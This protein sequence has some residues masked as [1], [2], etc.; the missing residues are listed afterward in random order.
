[1]EAWQARDEVVAMTGDGVNDAP[2]LRQ[3]DIG[4]AMGIRGTDV[5]KGAADMVL[6]DDNFATIVN[7]VEEGRR[8]FDN[9]KKFIHFILSCN[10]GE[11]TTLLF[12]VL[13]F[14]PI[15]LLPI[16]ILWVNLVTDG[17]PALALGID[18]T[19]PDVMQ[20]DVRKR[21]RVILTGRR[22]VRMT[23]QGLMKGIFTLA[24]FLISIHW[25]N[26]GIMNEQTILEAQ[27]MAFTVLVL[28]PALP[29][30]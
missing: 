27:T 21:G 28:K 7:A 14:L 6:A 25:L 24:A 4:I 22:W 23:V 10:I 5:T 11:I 3:A 18:T 17:L 13:L 16:H 26:G 1:M 29:L 8:I 19:A 30:A 12:A 2:A 20:Q 15:P 9:I